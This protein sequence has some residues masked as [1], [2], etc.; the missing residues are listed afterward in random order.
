MD[1]PL[2]LRAPD[3]PNVRNCS[4]DECVSEHLQPR[5]LSYDALM[6]HV[7]SHSPDVETCLILI[8]C[9]KSSEDPEKVV[10]AYEALLETFP[11]IVRVRTQ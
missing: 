4:A 8:A 2:S 7:R 11:N 9:A 6:V 1:N 3:D 10:A 5:P